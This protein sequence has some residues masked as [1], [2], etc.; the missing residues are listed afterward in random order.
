MIRR[1]ELNRAL[2]VVRRSGVAADLQARLNPTGTGRPRALPVE[3]FLAGVI[4]A[5]AHKKTMSLVAVHEVLTVDIARSAQTAVGSRSL[6]QPGRPGRPVSIRQVRYL[7]ERVELRLAHTA[8]RAPDL[9]A[10][11]RRERAAALQ[12]ILDRLLAAT[13]PTHIRHPGDYAVD[14]TAVE[15]AAR[16]RRAR[17]GA[18]RAGK[19][20]PARAGGGDADPPRPTPEEIATQ[21]VDDDTSAA[22]D[23]DATWGYRT[24]TYQNK[25]NVFFGYDV[26]SLTRVPPVGGTYAAA[27]ALTERIVVTPA[28][29]D[30]VDPALGML[31][32]LG[33]DG[34]PVTVLL[35]DRAWSYKLPD[36]WAH[37]LRAR[38]LDGMRM[39]AGTAHCPATPD[40]LIDIRRPATL[41][42]GPELDE[43]TRRIDERSSYAFRRTAG[44]N[45]RGD[46]RAECPAEAGKLRCPLKPTSLLFPAEMLSIG[47]PP[48]AATAPACCT[49]RTVKIPA[50]ADAKVRQRHIWGSAAW[51]RSFRRRTYVE[52]AFGNLKNPNTEAVRRGWI[53]VVGLVRRLA[54]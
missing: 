12:N 42:A 8:G 47:A 30:V 14:G 39:I 9:T 44:P 48:D 37:Q 52:G 50:A 26:F 5:A 16:G 40:E 11:D 3:T 6:A 43:F 10:S 1:C 13:M 31:D 22:F 32:R 54:A 17:R 7:L 27:P 29:T 34:Q 15:S 2:A 4:L 35:A 25:S 33:A 38:D 20:Q 45:A 21:S 19:Q 24:R 53:A 36:R 41:G 51:V 49:Q 23:P 46:E 18:A 28:A